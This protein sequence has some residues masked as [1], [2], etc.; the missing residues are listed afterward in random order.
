MRTRRASQ[1]AMTATGKPQPQK[2]GRG[3]RRR[4][5]ACTRPD[6]TISGSSSTRWPTITACSSRRPGSTTS[7]HGGSGGASRRAT[8]VGPSGSGAT[9]PGTRTSSSG[10]RPT[11]RVS[12]CSPTAIAVPSSTATWCAGSYRA[13]IPRSRRATGRAGCWRPPHAPWIS[14]P[15]S[16]SRLSGHCSRSSRGEATTARSTASPTATAMPMRGCSAWWSRSRGRR[17]AWPPGTPIACIGLEPRD[18]RDEAEI[19][20]LAVLPDW[21]RQ[22]FARA[23]IFGACEHLGPASR[24]GRD[25]CRRGRLLPRD[26]L[27]GGEPGRAVPG[28]RAVPVPARA[29]PTR[30]GR[31]GRSVPAASC[32]GVGWG[33]RGRLIE[34]HTASR[35]SGV[36]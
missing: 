18:D 23:L 36:D 35:K 11:D 24:R 27:R 21:R 14:G 12:S 22:G 26:R 34:S 16:T 17:R 9:T 19:T 33:Q 5:V 7:W 13:R 28:R 30:P 6:P 2:R 4:P 15:G 29:C 1:S 3:R 31:G 32:G 25:R 20:A 10:G 8:A